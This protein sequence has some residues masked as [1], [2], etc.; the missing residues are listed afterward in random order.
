MK[1]NSTPKPTT[2]SHLDTQRAV[3]WWGTCLN[4]RLINFIEPCDAHSGHLHVLLEKGAKS[5]AV[6]LLFCGLHHL[7]FLF[8][9]ICRCLWLSNDIWTCYCNCIQHIA[10]HISV[11]QWFIT[12]CWSSSVWTV[13]SPS[14]SGASYQQW[15]AWEWS[16]NRSFHCPCGSEQSLAADTQEK[17]PWEAR[18]R[19][20]EDG[21]VLP[22]PRHEVVGAAPAF[23]PGASEPRVPH[24]HRGLTGC[25]PLL[26]C[27]LGSIWTRWSPEV[28]DNLNQS[29]MLWCVTPVCTP[30][31]QGPGSTTNRP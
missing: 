28:P 23:L 10:C 18:C 21:A 26:V 5:R 12:C 11:R 17:D 27:T 6:L 13:N 1:L 22:G 15:A 20:D 29:G 4:R 30:N 9:I 7:K 8:V 24:Q 31:F 3:S 25:V 2:A 16:M 19:E 14:S